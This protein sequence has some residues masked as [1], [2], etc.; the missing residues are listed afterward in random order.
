MCVFGYV[1]VCG[2]GRTGEEAHQGTPRGERAVEE[3][4][5]R[6]FGIYRSCFT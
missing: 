4:D 1:F 3:H 6:I 5:G 2:H